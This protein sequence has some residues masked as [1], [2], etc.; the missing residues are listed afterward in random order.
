M[1]TEVSC[2][3]MWALGLSTWTCTNA[4]RLVLSSSF[5]SSWAFPHKNGVILS[6]T[7]GGKSVSI[8]KLLSAIIE[9]PGSKGLKI[10]QSLVIFLSLQRPA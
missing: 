6:F 3:F 4:V 1:L 5:S 10:P 7:P 2:S 9:S 8:S